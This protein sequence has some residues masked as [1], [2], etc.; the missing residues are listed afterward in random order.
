MILVC[1]L[2]HDFLGT[3]ID[4]DFLFLFFEKMTISLKKKKEWGMDERS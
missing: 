4:D 1:K 3:S 2:M